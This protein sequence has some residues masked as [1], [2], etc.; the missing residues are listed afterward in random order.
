M[1]RCLWSFIIG[2]AL[3]APLPAAHAQ[4]SANREVVRG[5]VV[6]LEGARLTLRAEGGATS[7]LQLADNTRVVALS[8]GSLDNIMPGSFIGTAA[9]PGANGELVAQEVHIFPEAMRGTGEGHRPYSRGP[10][11]TMTNGTVSSVSSTPGGTARSSTMTNATVTAA[12]PSGSARRLTV[13]Y[14]DGDKE[15][16]KTVVV[17]PNVPVV[18]M[19]PAERSLL[20]PGAHVLAFATRQPDGSLSALAVNVGKDGLVP[21]M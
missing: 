9:M 13:T 6:S 5:T 2:V 14:K 10:Q 3:W 21:P 4:A 8:K 15:S 17:P 1:K 19:Q 18:T 7:T 16:Q 20:T 11:S 12:A